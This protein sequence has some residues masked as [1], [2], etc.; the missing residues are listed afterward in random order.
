VLKEC[1]EPSQKWLVYCEDSAQLQ[2]VLTALR[3]GEIDAWEY[4][5]KMLGDP[6]ATLR[7]FMADGGVLVAIRCL[8]EGVDL[9]A[10]SHALILASSQNPRQFI[11]RRG[12]VLRRAPGKALAVIHDA[13]VMPTSAEA[14]TLGATE[15]RRA[16]EFARSALNRT[17]GVTVRDIGLKLGI[18]IDSLV[19]HSIEEE[20]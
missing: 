7:R 10:L 9:P 1:F 4:H 15:L 17:A 12:R 19:E 5:T 3:A 13:L 16:L 20:E 2:A 14:L 8:D 18:D 6:P 11:Q